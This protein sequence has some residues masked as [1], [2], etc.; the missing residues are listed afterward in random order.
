MC[1]NIDCK[2]TKNISHVQIA[3]IY[4]YEITAIHT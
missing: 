1:I 3:V 2:G 4:M